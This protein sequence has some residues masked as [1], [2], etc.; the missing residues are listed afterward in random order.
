MHS[1][2]C[3]NMTMVV[4]RNIPLG[5]TLAL[6]MEAVRSSETSVKIDKTIQNTVIPILATLRASNQSIPT[7]YTYTHARARATKTNKIF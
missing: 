3:T 4:V 6:M 5:S 7:L 2:E 1:I